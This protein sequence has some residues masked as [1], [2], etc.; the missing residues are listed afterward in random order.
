MKKE[1][2]KV[3]D[4]TYAFFTDESAGMKSPHPPHTEMRRVFQNVRLEI[5]HKWAVVRAQHWQC[6]ISQSLYQD[7]WQLHCTL[8]AAKK[9][10]ATG[11]EAVYYHTKARLKTD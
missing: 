1:F 4:K 8:E 5:S 11:G 10:V 9:A 2:I 3:R 6:P 7:E